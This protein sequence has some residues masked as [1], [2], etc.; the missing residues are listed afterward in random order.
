MPTQI[1]AEAFKQDRY[2]GILYNSLLADGHNIALFDTAAADIGETR[3][4]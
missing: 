3:F 1:L 2:D 4:V